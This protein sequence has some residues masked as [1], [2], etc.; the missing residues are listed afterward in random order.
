MEKCFVCA[1]ND[2]NDDGDGGGDDGGDGLTT[3][4]MTTTTKGP[5]TTRS[6][7]QIIDLDDAGVATRVFGVHP[8]ATA[9]ADA[10]ATTNKDDR[11]SNTKI[12]NNLEKNKQ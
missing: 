8:S 11:D 1:D 3:T 6:L 5:V 4:T 10:T 12:N 7:A 9:T 2:N